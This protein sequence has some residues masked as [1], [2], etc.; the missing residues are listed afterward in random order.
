MKAARTIALGVAVFV[1][2]LVA[3]AAVAVGTELASNFFVGGVTRQ[4]GPHNPRVALAVGTFALWSLTCVSVMFAGASVGASRLGAHRLGIL[5]VAAIFSGAV[6]YG[7]LQLTTSY[8]ECA[9]HISF[10]LEGD[11]EC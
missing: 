5:V 11:G 1:L 7:F 9:W 4:S 8:N 6:S 3:L 2:E 10:P